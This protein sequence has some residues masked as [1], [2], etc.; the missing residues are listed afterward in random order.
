MDSVGAVEWILAF[1]SFLDIQRSFVVFESFCKFIL[2]DK[3]KSFS[4][5]LLGFLN[6]VILNLIF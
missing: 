1:D 2:V 5:K 3:L 6:G 4:A